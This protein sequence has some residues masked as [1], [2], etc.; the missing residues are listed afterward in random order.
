[1]IANLGSYVGDQMSLQRYLTSNS[2]ADS[3]R[4]FL[5][6]VIG[7]VIV[8]VM[9]VG[10]GVALSAWYMVNPAP[11]MPTTIDRIFPFFIAR[12]LPPGVSGLLIAAL[13]AATMSSITSGINAL[14]S[15]MMT[16]FRQAS[17]NAKSTSSARRELW[18]A[19]G[20]SLLIGIVATLAAGIVSNLGHLF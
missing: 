7:V 20:V 3:S 17:G 18:M 13:L 16:D 6:N 10:V 15:S 1:T 11:E 8:L 9:L 12:E 5:V 14:A 2:I 19:R 4:A